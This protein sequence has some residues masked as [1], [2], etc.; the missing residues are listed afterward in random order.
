V[1]WQEPVLPKSDKELY[2]AYLMLGSYR[3]VAALYACDESS[4]RKRVKRYVRTLEQD[5]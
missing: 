4:V 1:T 3:A 2:L 5:V